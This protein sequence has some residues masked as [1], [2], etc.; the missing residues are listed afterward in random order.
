[1]T[2][3]PTD[4]IRGPN[5]TNG[6]CWWQITA[7][8]RSRRMSSR[9]RRRARQV[10][11]GWLIRT[12]PSM[13]TVTPAARSSPLSRPSKQSPKSASILGHK[14]RRL[15]K[16]TRKVST[17]PYMF[18]ECKCNTRTRPSVT[19]A[20]ARNLVAAKDSVGTRPPVL[21][22]S[23][24][25]PQQRD[26]FDLH[27]PLGTNCHR[28]KEDASSSAGPRKNQPQPVAPGDPP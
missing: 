25:H 28:S 27:P 20:A 11:Q 24:S 9:T 19:D 6:Q 15:A 17:P 5:T 16:V 13:W 2:F 21:P 22:P 14:R 4:L 7:S 12:R 1:M 8:Y 18:P 23:P 26:R 3:L 10:V